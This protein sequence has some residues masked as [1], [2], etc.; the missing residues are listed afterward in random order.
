MAGRRSGSCGDDLRS[1]LS[2]MGWMGLLDGLVSSLAWPV[3]VIVVVLVLRP[4][5]PALLNRV[6]SIELPWFK[7]NLDAVE[8]AAKQL[9][10]ELVATSGSGTLPLAG[11]IRTDV[12]AD[13]DEPLAAPT[14]GAYSTLS[15]T[16]ERWYETLAVSPGAAV[17]LAHGDLERYLRLLVERAAPGKVAEGRVVGFGQIV[18]VGHSVGVLTDVDLN[19]LRLLTEA[20]NEILYSPDAEVTAQQA[21]TLLNLASNLGAKLVVDFSRRVRG[22]AEPD[23]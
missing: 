21:A 16:R 12:S 13:L 14:S 22:N 20:R 7:A 23:Q 3:A 5:L 19:A 2:P 9:D 10:S 4:H 6:R 15:A 18:M 11:S 1:S 17:I 8:E